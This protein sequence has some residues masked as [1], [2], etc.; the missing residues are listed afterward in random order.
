MSV[1]TVEMVDTIHGDATHDD[2]DNIPSNV[3][4]VAGYISG[5]NGVEWTPSDFARFPASKQFRIYQGFGPAPAPH[6][7]DILD[8]ES[9]AVTPAF[10][11]ELI[12]Q[13]VDN[14][15]TWTTV[16]GGDSA[17]AQVTSAVEN[18]GAHYWNGHVNYW[19]ADW[20]L[21]QAEAAAKVG[22]FIHGA[23]CI[24]VQWASPT[25]N[26]NT[27]LPGTSM[28]LRQSNCDLS[29]IDEK[30]QPSGGFSPLPQPEPVPVPQ[31]VPTPQPT[32][33]VGLLVVSVNGTLTPRTVHSTD[34]GKTWS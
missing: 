18:L 9:G 21:D 33:E 2:V 20:D 7:Y 31:P 27:N 30:W 14:G 34:G 29:V 4:A 3:P 26:P 25:S 11:A 17:L 22:T 32:T 24:G 28:T 5:T 8:V 13:R 1:P 23:S 10:A 19:L 6:G 12:K 16:Y 15:I